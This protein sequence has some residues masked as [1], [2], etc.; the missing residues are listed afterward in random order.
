M[1]FSEISVVRIYGVEIERKEFPIP[2][3][4]GLISKWSRKEVTMPPEL[5][6]IAMHHLIR[7]HGKKYAADISRMERRFRNTPREVTQKDIEGY[8]SLITKAMVIMAT[9]YAIYFLYRYFRNLGVGG[10]IRDG[11]IS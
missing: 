3:V 7:E 1:T 9:V 11:L 8:K 4:P 10:E 5:R 2:G 6:S